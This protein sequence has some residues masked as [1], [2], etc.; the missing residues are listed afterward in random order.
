[1]FS[2]DWGTLVAHTVSISKHFSP[3]I[4]QR[5]LKAVVSG[6]QEGTKTLRLSLQMVEPLET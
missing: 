1:M 2:S 4:A 6:A 3:R 5:F